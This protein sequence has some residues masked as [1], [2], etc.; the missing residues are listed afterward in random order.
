VARTRNEALIYT[1]VPVVAGRRMLRWTAHIRPHLAGI[2]RE[3]R[4]GNGGGGG[5][6][7]VDVRER[8]PRARTCACTHPRS[9]SGARD[10][11]STCSR[12]DAAGSLPMLGDDAPYVCSVLEARLASRFTSAGK[13]A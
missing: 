10:A 1:K 7:I 6:G 9:R 5:G 13:R 8:H 2:S 11:K 4:A 12:L 3:K